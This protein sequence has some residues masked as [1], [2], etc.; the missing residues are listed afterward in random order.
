MK[1]V[2]LGNYIKQIRGVS[3]S[4]GDSI[5]EEKF[6]YLPILRSNNIEESK[7]N[8][9]DLVY[10][11]TDF[12]KEEQLLKKGDILITASTGSIKVIGKNGCVNKDYNGS[13]GAFCKLVRPLKTI[14]SGYL[15][16]YFQS[17]SYRNYIRNIV[18]G[19]N[20]NN[21]KNGHIDGIKIPLPPLATQKKIAAILD[22]ADA[23][24][25]KTKTLID[26]Y[27]Q[28][29]QSLFLDMF[30]DP[31]TNPKGWEKASLKELCDF[32]KTTI[33]PNEINDGEI[34]I[35]LECIEK[36]SGVIIE[37]FEVKEGEIKSNKFW[38]D[39]NYILYGKLRPYLNKVANPDFEGICSTDII[40]IKPLIEKTS[41]EFI[42]SLMRGSWF[43]AFADERSSGA[44]LPR[45]SP[46]DVEKYLAINPPIDLQ[47][48]FAARVQAIETQKT[49]AQQVLQQ[50]D[51]LFNSLLQKA[52]KGELVT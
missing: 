47:N 28:L 2:E 35:G 9:D 13:F 50:A 17:K 43:V 8:F 48:Q 10:V 7:L 18:N 49:L 38:F 32:K 46:K 12:V 5:K 11:P 37:K 52:F 31:V 51:N 26:K 33:K 6:G 23:Y 41:K 3:Y 39:K 1:K 16:H 21:I 34:Y 14:D 45:I 30:G 24:R 4:S 44:N 15:K 40:P 25:Q 20:I 22:A 27:D 42:V 29:T 36:Q 19:A